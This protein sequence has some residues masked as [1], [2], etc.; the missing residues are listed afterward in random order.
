MNIIK[1]VFA[2]SLLIAVPAWAAPKPEELAAAQAAEARGAEMYAYDQAAW[3]ATD[4][5]LE[6][7][8]KYQPNQNGLRGYVVEADSGGLLKTTFFAERDGKLFAFA[9]YWVRGSVVERGG[10]VGPD[11]ASELSLLALRMID[12]RNK[13]ID[14]VAK[15]DHGFCADAPPNSLVLPPRSDG[16]IPVY[17]MT[18]QTANGAYPAGGHYRF[19]F[20]ARNQLI[21]ERRFMKTCMDVNFRQR[22]DEKPEMFVVSHLLDPQPTEIHAFVSRYVPISLAIITATNSEIWSVE[23]GR[24]AYVGPVEDKEPAP[25]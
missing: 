8:K 17:I 9:T 20:D 12:A 5:F 24:I 6:D 15:P 10:L 4:R 11:A 2:L 21:G 3:H 13:A 14:A 25:H 1:A 22:G 19:D 18:P 23:D 7:L 16:S